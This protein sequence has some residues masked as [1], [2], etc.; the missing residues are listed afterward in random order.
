MKKE[1]YLMK[2]TLFFVILTLTLISI[3]YLPNTFAQ[4]YTQWHL[5]EGTKARLGKGRV[6][7]DIAYSP[8][9]TRLAVASSIGI[10][11]YDVHTGEEVALLTGHTRDVSGVVFSSDGKMLASG[12]DDNT[13]RLW[14]VATGTEKHILKG[15]RYRVS[16]VSFSPDGKTL[17]SGSYQTIHL[18]DVATGTEKHIL[19]GQA[20]YVS[21]VSFSPDGSTLASASR[22]NTIHLWDVETGTHKRILGGHTGGVLG[23]SFSLD[24]RTLASGSTDGTILLWD[25]ETGAEKRNLKGH[26]RGVSTIVF[27]PDGLTLASKSW[28]A[29][30]LWDIATGAVQHILEGHTSSIYHIAFSPDGET[31]TSGSYDKTI[32]V[33]DVETGT[34]KNILEV[35]TLSSSSVFFSSVAFSPDGKTLASGSWNATI[36]LWDMETGT[37]K[38]ILKGH[39]NL[40][41]SV[42]YRSVISVV[43][44]PDGKTLASG[45]YGNIR[46][47]DVATGTQ[48]NILKGHTNWVDSVV[49]SPDGKTLASGCDGA[50]LSPLSHSGG[51]APDNT[52]RLWDVKTGA[53][54]N[55]LEGHTRGI[56]SVAFSPDGKTLASGSGDSTIRLWDVAT[57]TEKKMFLG[58]TDDVFNIAFSPDGETL[59]SGS[60]DRTFRLWD[61]ATG[62]QKHILKGYP[63]GYTIAF[64]PV[65]FS[66]DGKT[67]AGAIGGYHTRETTIRLWDVETGTEQSILNGHTDT[68][69]SVAFSPDGKTLASGSHDG[70]VLLWDLAPAPTSDAIVSLSPSTVPSPDI[71]EQLTFSLNITD[72]EN[73]AGYQATVLFDT[74]ALRYVESTNG[75]F[76]PAGAFFVEP[77]VEGNLIKL[78]AA[79][80]AGESSGNGTLATLTF[81]VIAAQ[82]STLTLSDVLLSNSAGEAFLPHVEDAEITEPERLK[83]D[84][85]GDG[86]INIQD[87]VLVASNLGK[88]GQNAADV[89]GDGIVNI[90]DLVLVAGAL[91]TTA[92][93]APTL[94]TQA[95]ST[96][97]ATDV[98][99]WLSQA[100]QLNLTD[101]TSQRGILFLEQLL[102]ALT[103]KET[104]LLPNYPNPFNPETWIPYQLAKPADVS[105]SIYAV[106]GQLV[107]TLDL[108][109]Q[110]VGIYQ[111]RSRAAHWDGK[112]A[113]GESVASG[114]Y[115]YTFTTDDFSATRKML[116][117]K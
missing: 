62:A 79:S 115:F 50:Y 30:W 106:D 61:V 111:N 43:F 3:A 83:G 116:I 23:V 22:D 15:S 75:D 47:W 68:V 54:K 76:L 4:D 9:G 10:W 108:G 72:S 100:Q 49:F 55:V 74:T 7:G 51:A 65:A 80:L 77:A 66:P 29:I 19:G 53:Q 2:K 104:A 91:G 31:L 1:K 13:V 46:L 33:W 81:A 101:A 60:G 16:S 40:A 39:T 110:A 98:K 27:S 105:I 56:N 63:G 42:T 37:Q 21:S 17:A 5:P 11:L 6:T 20:D 82:P 114:V 70:T 18:W 28:E 113:L 57:G 109:H 45:S 87:L 26:T 107:R 93:A 103:P 8:D 88:S 24:G 97:T 44:S 86:I 96:L 32:R 78:S 64:S 12:S 117:M 73:V 58:H 92:A 41:R 52:V 84:V 89:N 36:Y 35:H 95:L 38:R 112:N 25:V 67:L 48:K 85:N 69:T 59:A 90:Q 14:D 99:A 34:Q 102:A 94:H 71:G